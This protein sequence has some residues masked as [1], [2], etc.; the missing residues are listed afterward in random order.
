MEEKRRDL[1]EKVDEAQRY[2]ICLA[3][4]PSLSESHSLFAISHCDSSAASIVV[5]VLHAMRVYSFKH[6]RIVSIHLINLDPSSTPVAR[7]S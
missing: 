2:V 7:H 6:C 3:P 4:P 1:Q 5:V